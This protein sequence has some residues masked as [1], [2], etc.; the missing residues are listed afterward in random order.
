MAWVSTRGSATTFSMWLSMEFS[1]C[2]R[3]PRSSTSAKSTLPESARA[4]TV[5]PSAA[6]INSPLALSS[7]RAF[8]CLGL[9][10]A[11]MM[12]PP[13]AC[14]EITVISTVGV[15]ERPVS[16]T[17]TPMPS[18]VP[19][20]SES[21]MAPDTRASRPTTMVMRFLPVFCLRKVAN[22]EA[23]FTTSIG[24]SP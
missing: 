23:N 20:T 9:W 16:T 11:V 19:V 5:L 4:S 17:S 6:S 2:V 3:V 7:L 18:K 12:M 15:V 10:L 13:S 14:C 24:V 22:A 1:R 8:Q 21:T